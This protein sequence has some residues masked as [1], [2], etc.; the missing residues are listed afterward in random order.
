MEGVDGVRLAVGGGGRERGHSPRE[1]CLVK[2]VLKQALESVLGGKDS[3]E[4]YREESVYHHVRGGEG[5]FTNW[6]PLPNS[7][8]S[9]WVTFFFFFFFGRRRGV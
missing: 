4:L 2:Y 8:N 7:T 6:S 3:P 1:A 5:K 9:S